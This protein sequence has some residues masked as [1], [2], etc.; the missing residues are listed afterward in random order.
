MPGGFIAELKRFYYDTA[1][2]AN[3]GALASLT[4]LVSAGQIVFGT[5][6]PP[7]GTSA[8]VAESL[9]RTGLFSETELRAI[10]RG[11]AVRLFPRFA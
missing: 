9:S 2:A 4:T 11:N 5:D 1:G 8:A 10:D 6:F 7:G 3:K